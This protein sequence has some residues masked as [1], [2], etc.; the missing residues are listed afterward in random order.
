M[1]KNEIYL[2]TKKLIKDEK[3]SILFRYVAGSNI[4][5]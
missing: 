4:D 3:K 5:D 1:T 2:L